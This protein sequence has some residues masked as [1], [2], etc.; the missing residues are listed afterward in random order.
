MPAMELIPPDPAPDSQFGAGLFYLILHSD[1]YNQGMARRTHIDPE[2]IQV[3][4]DA[5]AAAL[6]RLTGRRSSKLPVKCTRRRT[7]SSATMSD[8]KTLRGLKS[9]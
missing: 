9:R 6:R 7:K 1:W 2:K 3:I 5:T 8:Y 4:D